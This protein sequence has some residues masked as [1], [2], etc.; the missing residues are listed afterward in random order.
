MEKKSF[1]RR[2]SASEIRDDREPVLL[3]R[4]IIDGVRDL[5][6]HQYA[7]ITE[8]VFD[9]SR[10]GSGKKFI[11]H[12]QGIPIPRRSQRDLIAAGKR[13]FERFKESV[14]DKIKHLGYVSGFS[15][16]PVMGNDKL[17]RKVLF[18]ELL[19]AARLMAYGRAYH[20]ADIRVEH[21]YTDAQRVAREGGAFI[22]STPSRRKKQPRYEFKVSNIPVEDNV[23]AYANAYSFSSQNLGV[24]SKAMRELRFKFMD[25]W[26]SSSYRYI[27]SHEIAGLYA[28]A[29]ENP[30]TAEFM[31]LPVVSQKA[32]ELYKVLK[33]RTLVQVRD[34]KDKLAVKHLGHAHIEPL[35][36]NM[37]RREGFDAGF[38]EN[39]LSEVRG[40][41]WNTS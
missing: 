35:M 16:Y 24:K 23:F 41:R 11:K 28:A 20:E 18:V 32:V 15:F 12:G 5:K 34:D 31:V 25:D 33:D 21:N 19:E 9:F 10:W 36:W 22:V 29:E 40:Y 3:E 8:K 13:P 1:F 17:M 2:P 7:V 26:E 14:E 6:E 37:V 39:G 4:R 30:V 38:N 27:Q